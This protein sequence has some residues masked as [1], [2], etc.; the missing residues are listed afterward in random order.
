[1]TDRV[2]A[3]VARARAHGA[4]PSR[5]PVR[6]LAVGDPQ[7]SSERFFRFLDRA[8]ALGDDGWLNPEVGLV[9]IG[10]HFDYGRSENADE[11]ATQGLA[12]LRW[13]AAHPPERVLLIAGNH[14]LSRVTELAFESDASF[15]DARKLV[16][17]IAKQ[18]D[19]TPLRA[20]FGRRFPHIPTPE[21][22]ARDYAAFREEQR[23]LVQQLL[24]DGRFVLGAATELDGAPALL[25]HAGLS[26]RELDILGIPEVRDP[27]AIARALNDW[28]T[29]AVA[30]VEGAWRR[31]EQAALALE[32]LHVAGTT[33][34][35]GGGF[36]Y[37]RPVNSQR[38][39]GRETASD[40][41]SDRPR[42]FDATRLPRGLLQIV[43]HTAH[44][45]SREE[46]VPWV[47]PQAD[48]V[49]RGG[50]LRTLR[51]DDAPVYDRGVLPHHAGAATVVMI[52]CAMSDDELDDIELLPIAPP[53]RG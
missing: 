32:P 49:L 2:S 6:W 29:A 41:A 15:A 53:N 10:D 44:K 33:G 14:D 27:A 3:A 11:A 31:G 24:L 35:E 22:A 43:G 34:L 26:L 21:L 1:M 28:L 40:L 18:S 52:D 36:L 30:R 39:N 25:V 23:A 4:A 37:H 51:M 16:S 45:R 19:P 38:P 48:A 47:T 9:S 50:G 5:V 7:T 20:E 12:I 13:L 42:R 8:G 17:D 46:L